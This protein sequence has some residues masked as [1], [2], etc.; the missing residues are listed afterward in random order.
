MKGIQT[1]DAT[2]QFV[3]PFTNRLAIPTQLS[4]GSAGPTRAEGFDRA[5]EMRDGGHCL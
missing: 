5:R 4:F 3:H 2:F 1:C